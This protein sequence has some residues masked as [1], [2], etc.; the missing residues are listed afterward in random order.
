MR[1]L[2]SYPGGLI[3]TLPANS[4]GSFGDPPANQSRFIG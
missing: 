2:A 1:A 3:V 4:Q